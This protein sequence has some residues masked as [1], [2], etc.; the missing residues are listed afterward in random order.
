MDKVLLRYLNQLRLLYVLYQNFHWQCHGL[1]FYS[2][3]LLFQ[4]LYEDI[5]TQIDETAEKFVGLFKLNIDLNDFI[6]HLNEI[7]NIIFKEKPVP[8]DF[9]KYAITLEEELIKLNQDIYKE[10]KEIS[11]G[12]DNMLAGQSDSAENRLYLLK[13][14]LP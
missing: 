9:F 10:N 12:L 2:N 11:P 7:N 4:R 1:N 8:L 13:S 5:Q 14:S 3:H 6:L